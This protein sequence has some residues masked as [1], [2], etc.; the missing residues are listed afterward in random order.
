[1]DSDKSIEKRSE[2]SPDTRIDNVNY[3]QSHASPQNSIEKEKAA[4]R[5]TGILGA[6]SKLGNLPE[7]EVPGYGLLQGKALNNSIA[8]CS[9]LAFLMFGYDQGV[10]SG[11]LTLDDFQRH[12]PLMTPRERPNNLCWL[13]APTN[14]I[15]DPS[16][17]T[18]S[19]SILSAAVAVYQIG[20]FLGAVL[21][22]FYGEVWGRKSSSFWGSLVMIIGTVL[23]VVAGGTS[24]GNEGAYAVLCI[25]RVVGG[26]GNGM[27]TATIPTWQ[28]ECAK[29]EKRGRLIITS[30]AVIVA[31]VMISYWVTYG[32]YFLPSGESYSSVRWRFPIIFQSFFTILVMIGL[33]FLPDSPRWLVMRGRY[34]EAR[35]L[36]ARLAGADVNSDEVDTE[37]TN[38]KDALE[39]Q[40]KDGPFKMKELLHNGPSQNLRRTLLGVVSQFFQQISGINLITYYATYVFEN[41]LGFGPDMSRLLSACNGTEYFLAGL[42][43]IPLIERAGRRKLMLFGAIGQMASMA[44]MSGMT[45][46]ATENEFG[47]PV[48]EPR[49]GITAVVFMFGF[50][51]FFAI[52]WLGMTWLYP[53]EITNL[54]IRIQANALSTCSNWL[55]N[56]LIVMITPPA[57]ANLTYNTYTMFAVFNACL[58]PSVYFFFPEPKGRSLEELDV[59]FASAHQQGINPVKQAKEMPK[60]VGRELDVEI[61]RYFGGD[62]EDARRRSSIARGGLRT[63][64]DGLSAGPDHKVLHHYLQKQSSGLFS[65][66]VL[67][68]LHRK[69]SANPPWRLTEIGITTYDRASVNKSQPVMAG[70]HAEDLLRK[71]WC[72]HLVIRE[73]VH[74]DST[75]YV[76]DPFHFGTTVYV[77]Q[78]EALSLLHEIWHQPMDSSNPQSGFRP[79]IYM[80]FG[81][82]DGISRTRKPAFDFDPTTVDTTVATLDAQIIPQQTKI[83][84][85]ADAALT[86][87]LAQFK[88]LCH[89]PDN[90]GNAAMY[91]T[92]AAFLS[93]LRLEFYSAID[94][95]AAKPGRTGQSSSKA[96]ADVVQGLMNWPTPPPPGSVLQSGLPPTR[97]RSPSLLIES[98]RYPFNTHYPHLPN[99]AKMAGPLLNLTIFTKSTPHALR[100]ICLAVFLPAFLVL[101]IQG[102][103]SHRVNPAIG[104]L[105]LFFSSAYSGLLLA[106]EKKCGCQASGLTG[107]PIHFLCDVLLG[108][109]LLLCL[110]LLIHAYFAFSQLI[111]ALQPGSFYPA[112]CP[113]CQNGSFSVGKIRLGAGLADGY[114]PL[115]DGENEPRGST[116]R[117]AG[118]EGDSMC[119]AL[120]LVHGSNK[121]S[122]SAPT[123]YWSHQ[124][125]NVEPYCTFTPA[126]A[127]EVSTLVLLARLTQCPFALKSGGHAAFQASSIEG[128]IIVDTVHMSKLKLSADKKAVV[129]PDNRWK[130]ASDVGVGGLTPGGGISHHTNE[131]GLACDNIASCELVTASGIILDV[132]EKTFSDLYWALRGGSNN[133]GITTSFNYETLDFMAASV[134]KAKELGVYNNYMYMPYSSPYKPVI[135]GY[136][137]VNVARLNRTA[138]KYDPMGV[139]QRLQPGYF[140]LDGATPFGEVI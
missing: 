108:I 30:G 124:Q 59:I 125:F 24:G 109:G 117:P 60:L 61:A 16:M 46:T 19:P 100:A 37:L 80:F 69:W 76:L 137:E 79:V 29:P 71:V 17:C 3:H 106:N 43:A 27:V 77:S 72:L 70:P 84:R 39:A 45:S 74:L 97:S 62:V 56:F 95:A 85:H 115:L 110:V 113:Q 129:G 139:F 73:T 81:A 58:I 131:Y 49:Y 41:S 123:K 40:S 83:T 114:A 23:Q 78:D 42:I 138:K 99:K 52:G 36:L 101:L 15:P 88:I 54:R 89:H 7:W 63:L 64:R 111:E 13:D 31:G 4:D 26:I 67:T 116:D 94:N 104:I 11:V 140:K 107:T 48:L 98:G 51:T 132:S 119:N 65:H 134:E 96:A 38:I 14:T 127:F 130:V 5:R 32:F 55:S 102:I 18:G 90:S 44:I 66:A 75:P 133:F 2:H 118:G 25:G 122:S 57:F 103:A 128:G 120:D 9:C 34:T 135:S 35:L 126:T 50:N 87:L 82:N 93:A 6:F 68:T 8:W 12:F 92:I 86:Y 28:S 105:P 121:V 53:A 1:M 33:L 47:A 136:E 10:L 112:S 21:I 20:C 91:A 22:L